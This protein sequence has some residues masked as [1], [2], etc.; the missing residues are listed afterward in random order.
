MFDLASV[1]NARDTLDIA[2]IHARL[3]LY[4][5]PNFPIAQLLLAEIA[6]ELNHHEEALSLY[7]AVDPHSSLSWSARLREAAMLDE[8]NRTDEA[9]ALLR[10][11][12]AERP[13]DRQPVIE[14]G[15]ILRSHDRFKE[16]V[17]AYDE[18]FAR[19]GQ[20][21]PRDWRLYYSRGIALERSQQWPRAEADLRYA[22]EL[23]PEQPLV[24]NYL[25]YSWI[26]QGIHLDR[27]LQMVER[28]VA[29]RPNDG[30]IVDSLGW[31][32][33][34]LGKYAQATENLERAI[35]LVPED[36]TVNDHL[37]DAYWRTGRHLE[38][39]FQWNR[40]LQFKPE[41]GE[42]SKIESKLEHGLGQPLTVEQSKGG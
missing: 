41:A 35:E 29:L 14:L 27:A 30:Y 1:L 2:L 39:R 33:F 12:A 28:A 31:A 19:F 8:L 24:L 26:D 37:G 22:L 36:P 4:L 38:A 40:A 3:A 42:I 11:M 17:G 16:A 32:F 7:R 20:N 6:E 10:S 21:K 9:I 23:E 25:G 15:D 5:R 13:S 34:R 18:A